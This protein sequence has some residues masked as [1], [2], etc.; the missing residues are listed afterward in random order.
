M[1][2]SGVYS[3]S[4]CLGPPASLSSHVMDDETIKAFK[5]AL[6]AYIQRF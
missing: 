3:A 4:R 5:E 2:A 1:R 6:D